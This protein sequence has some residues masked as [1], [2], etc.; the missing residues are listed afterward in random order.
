MPPEL[1]QTSEHGLEGEIALYVHRCQLCGQVMEDKGHGHVLN[2]PGALAFLAHQRLAAKL[3]RPQERVIWI[4]IQLPHK[5]L[6]VM[7]D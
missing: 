1:P 6:T 2:M 4:C 5:Q 3:C 7:Q